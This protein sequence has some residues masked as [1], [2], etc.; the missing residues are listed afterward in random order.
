MSAITLFHFEKQEVRYVG[1]GINHEWVA[2]DIGNVLEIQNIRQNLAEFDDDEKGV[3]TIYTPGGSQEML[4]VTEPGLYRLTFKSRK[5][6]ARR[7]KR[8]VTH[9]VLPSIRK[10]GSYS[11]DQARENLERDFLPKA[12][13]REIDQAAKIYGKRFG[14]AYEESYVQLMIK[15]H[16]PHLLGP[17]VEAKHRTSLNS[18]AALLTPTEI[19]KVLGITCKTSD[20]PDPKAV[21]KLLEQL[22]YQ[23]KIEGKWSATG[24]GQKHADRKPVD[25]NSKSDKDQLLWYTSIIPILQEHTSSRSAA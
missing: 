16:Q 8:W 2:Q 18:S 21:N 6:I 15:R 22:G 14:K 19:A 12:T 9:E 20:T 4:T 25:T 7:F 1:D 11:L 17:A 5:Q 13:L 24:M 10:T 3:C 23:E